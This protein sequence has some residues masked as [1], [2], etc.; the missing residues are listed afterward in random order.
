VADLTMKRCDLQGCGLTGAGAG[1]WEIA[2]GGPFFIVYP[3]GKIPALTFPR[4]FE[5]VNRYDFCGREHA[6]EFLREKMT[7]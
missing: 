3:V 7:P 5:L 4:V 1:W 6:L 2:Y